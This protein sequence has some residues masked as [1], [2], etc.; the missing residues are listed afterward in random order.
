MVSPTIAVDVR[1]E[2]IA[3]IAAEILEILPAA[4][5]GKALDNNFVL[6]VASRV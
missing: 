3:S 2:H 4:G 5:P 6:R 1:E